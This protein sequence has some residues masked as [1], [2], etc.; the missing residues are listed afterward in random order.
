MKEIKHAYQSGVMAS[1]KN[2]T[3]AFKAKVALGAIKSDQTLVELLERFQ[4]HP[5][6]NAPCPD[7]SVYISWRGRYERY[8]SHTGLY[9]RG[10]HQNT[11]ND[12]LQRIEPL[13]RSRRHDCPAR[14][15]NRRKVL[16]LMAGDEMA[17]SF[18]N[19]TCH[20]GPVDSITTAARWRD[21]RGAAIDSLPALVR[22][23]RD[24]E[25]P[26]MLLPKQASKLV[27]RVK[28]LLYVYLIQQSCINR[29]IT[30]LDPNL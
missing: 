20:F 14:S 3:A 5:N 28:Y 15:L 30:T 7:N 19:D 18:F 13:E 2:H 9:G 1:R 8:N 21:A 25:S 6:R 17:L 4:I 22:K 11:E 27:R 24:C 26:G 10:L 12:D 16:L 23:G 29:S